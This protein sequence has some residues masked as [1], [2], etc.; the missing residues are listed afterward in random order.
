ME[1]KHLHTQYVC[2][3]IHTHVVCLWFFSFLGSIIIINDYSPNLFQEPV[4]SSR[5][6]T[7]AAAVSAFVVVVVLVLLTIVFVCL[8]SFLYIYRYTNIYMRFFSS[9][10]LEQILNACEIVKNKYVTLVCTIFLSAFPPTFLWPQTEI[11]LTLSARQR[12]WLYTCA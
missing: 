8:F 4:A 7:T 5:S 10:L 1:S 2:I 6:T 3:H 9:L 12:C 11:N